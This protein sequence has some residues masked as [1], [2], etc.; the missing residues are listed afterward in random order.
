LVSVHTGID[1][2]FCDPNSPGNAAPT[3]TPTDC[4]ANYFPK[5][6]DQ[7]NVTARDLDRVAEELEDRPRKR[8]GFYKP[9]ERLVEL[10]LRSPQG[11]ADR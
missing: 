4:C 11:S 8:L 10:L 1:I 7:G 3:R 9:T 6:T 2:Y 5:G